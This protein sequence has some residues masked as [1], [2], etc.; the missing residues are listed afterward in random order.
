ML[1]FLPT[2]FIALISLLALFLAVVGAVNLWVK[3][4]T[5]NDD[6]YI[7]HQI[8]TR[9]RLFWLYVKCWVILVAG[10]T[11]LLCV[12]M[13]LLMQLLVILLVLLATIGIVYGESLAEVRLLQSQS[14]NLML[15]S[16]LNPHFLY[17]TLNNIDA[18]I[19][20]DQEKASTAVTNLSD[21]MRYF[22]YSARQDS[23]SLADEISHLTQL[24]ELQRL[25]MPLAE[26][27]TFVT[28]VEHP[29]AGIAPL[30]LLPLIENCFKHCGQLNEPGAIRLQIVETDGWLD[31]R[32]DNNVKSEENPLANNTKPH[33]HGLG[34]KVLR[35]RLSLLYGEDFLLESESVDGRYLTHLRVK[36]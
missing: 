29:K 24:V 17:N 18:L 27:L 8:Y 6:L 21:L 22:T 33:Q 3:Y 26:S 14:E 15:R 34:M 13:E 5:W 31:Y 16:Q 2:P 11:L 1:G 28:R 7:V 25:R 10:A 32:S 23:V 20:L 35:Q 12:E 4:R 9:R 19:W 30:L 36:L